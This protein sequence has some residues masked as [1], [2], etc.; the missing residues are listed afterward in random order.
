MRAVL[1]VLTV[2]ALL[3]PT[4]FANAQPTFVNFESGH[5]RPLALSPDGTTLFAVNTPDN[6]LEI[7]DVDASGITHRESVPV[8]MEPVAVAARTNDEVWVVN[9]L[10]DSVSIVDV[11][12]IPPRVVRTLL[13]G[14][15]PRDIVFAGTGGNRAFITTAHR[16]QHRTDASI[17]LV[18]GSGD[19]QLTTPGIGRADVWV[20]DATSLG[21]AFGGVPVE[22]KTFFTDTPRALAVSNDGNTVYVA[23][24]HTGNQTTTVS[25]GS[26]CNGFAAAGPCGG[27]GVTSPGGL[28]GGQMPGG[29]PGPSTD[30]LGVDAP[31]VGLIV[32]F[33]QGT[34]LWEDEL[35]RNWNNGVRFNL[36]DEDVFALNA[37]TLAQSAVHAGVGTTLFNMV[38]HPTTGDLFVTNT[39]A[40]N[41]TRFEGPGIHGRQRRC[42]AHLAEAQCHRHRR[43]SNGTNPASVLPRHLN[44]HIELQPQLAR[45]PGFDA[46]A[47]S[48]SLATPLDMAISPER[49]HDPLRRGFRLVASI[50]VLDTTHARGRQFRPRHGRQ[51]RLHRR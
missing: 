22:I 47:K 49:R 17:A 45:D 2:L 37:N 41:E 46:T 10:S 26:V 5:V 3:A 39:E 15:E 28:A 6:H 44:K 19:P 31:E 40:I 13:V 12:A 23:G 7:F 27:D 32:K 24:F 1:S 14:D 43:C 11:T 4:N 48:H 20:F 36:P 9:H 34:G 21:A 25:E 51:R 42:R 35:G 16:G 29:N 18:S 38:V 33:N 50:G 30:H 8:G